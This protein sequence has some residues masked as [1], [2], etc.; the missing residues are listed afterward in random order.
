MTLLDIFNEAKSN[1]LNSEWLMIDEF[2]EE[3]NL[4]TIFRYSD[5]RIRFEFRNIES[6]KSNHHIMTFK[7]FEILDYGNFKRLIAELNHYA[8]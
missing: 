8:I 7:E 5:K 6:R 4:I 2:D 3:N 1:Y